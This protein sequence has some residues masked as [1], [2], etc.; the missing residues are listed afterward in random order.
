MASRT[1]A[2]C[3]ATVNTGT[4]RGQGRDEMS[5]NGA[6]LFLVLTSIRTNLNTPVRICYTGHRWEEEL[7]A[8]VAAAVDNPPTTNAPLFAVTR[9][10][11]SDARR[12]QIS[13]RVIPD[14]P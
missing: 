10:L 9:C 7:I 4:S 13:S 5:M 6:G 2:F 3:A 8:V 12:P 1:N 11:H 14:T